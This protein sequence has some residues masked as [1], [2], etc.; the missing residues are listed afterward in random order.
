MGSSKSTFN[1]QYNLVRDNEELNLTV[2]GTYTYDPSRYSGPPEYCYP[3]EEYFSYKILL[4]GK[5]WDDSLS[6]Q[7]EYDLEEQI[8]LNL[9]EPDFNEDED[10]YDDND[11]EPYYYEDEHV[12]DDH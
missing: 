7:E 12:W 6:S 9:D 8:R 5:E 2:V 3:S 10:D 4:D 1:M 11:D